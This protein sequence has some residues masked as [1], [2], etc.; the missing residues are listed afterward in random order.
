MGAEINR[1]NGLTEEELRHNLQ[2]R[3]HDSGAID[4]A[5]AR[6]RVQLLSQV[7]TMEGTGFYYYYFFP[8]TLC[9]NKVFVCNSERFALLL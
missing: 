8:Q 2:R 6:L 9:K 3:L 7:R 5:K 4:S 1:W